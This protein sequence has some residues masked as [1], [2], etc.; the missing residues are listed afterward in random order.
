MKSQSRVARE[1][2]ERGWSVIR[3]AL[4]TSEIQSLRDAFKTKIESS[5]KPSSEILYTHS[6]APSESPGMGNLMTQWLNPHRSKGAG[7]TRPLAAAIKGTITGLIGTDPVL[8][9]DILMMKEPGQTPFEWHQDFPF[10]PVDSHQGLI[11]WIPAQDVDAE[12]GGL[13]FADGSHLLGAGHSVDL[14]SGEAQELSF[15]E[16]PEGLVLNTPELRAGDAVVFTSLTWHRSDVNRSSEPRMA[17]SSTWL[18][19]TSRWDLTRAPN[20][21]LSQELKHGELVTEVLS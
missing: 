6:D 7:S 19:K 9:Q 14:H 20:H 10:W 4:S 21:P 17:W 5:E 11:V 15:G 2:A 18:P 13:G 12:N 16:V 8:F 3:G 1:L